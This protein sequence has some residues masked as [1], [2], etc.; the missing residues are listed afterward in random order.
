MFTHYGDNGEQYNRMVC[1]SDTS[2]AMEYGFE[3]SVIK[4]LTD[5][6]N[7]YHSYVAI[8]SIKEFN[9]ALIKCGGLVKK[10]MS[11]CPLNF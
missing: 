9:I 11:I 7:I 4:Y 3:D 10:H 6:N 1:D 5:K 8:L 2:F